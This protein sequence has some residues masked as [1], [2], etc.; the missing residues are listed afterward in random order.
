MMIAYNF[1]FQRFVFFYFKESVLE[2]VVTSQVTRLVSNKGEGWEPQRSGEY[3]VVKSL[4][5]SCPK[6]MLL[7]DAARCRSL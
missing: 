5:C 3:S 7:Y 6:A 4:L 2:R 1:F